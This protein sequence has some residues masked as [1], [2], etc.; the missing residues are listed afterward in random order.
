MK[1]MKEDPWDARHYLIHADFIPK[2]TLKHLV[3]HGIGVAVQ[4]EVMSAVTDQL[5]DLM[6]EA[7]K[8]RQ[9]PLK[10]MVEA[11][12]HI[13]QGTDAPCMYPNWKETFQAAVLRE[14]KVTGKIIGPGQ[15]ITPR[16]AIRMFTI[17]G[18]WLDHMDHIKGSIEVE[19]LA[20]ICVLDEDILEVDLHRIKEI[21]TVMTIVG[22]K[23]VY[24]GR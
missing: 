17:E 10:E 16:E 12:I 1:A 21:K 6:G 5:H 23:V 13:S 15:R 24:E 8:A 18:A 7:R 11:G 14:S 22:G 4:S 19:K 3:D 20:D 2:D 9:I